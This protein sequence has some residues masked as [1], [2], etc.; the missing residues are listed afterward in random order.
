MKNTICKFTRITAA[1]VMGVALNPAQPAMAGWT[2][3]MNG[4]G[5]GQA[6]VNVRAYETSLAKRKTVAT[7]CRVPAWP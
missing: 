1:I 5:F 6:S 7:T 2:G 3:A 4:T